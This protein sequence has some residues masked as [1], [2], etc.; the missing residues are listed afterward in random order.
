MIKLTTQ[1]CLNYSILTAIGSAFAYFVDYFKICGVEKDD[2]EFLKK[3]LSILNVFLVSLSSFGQFGV[4]LISFS[5]ILNWVPIDRDP[6]N[7]PSL[8]SIYKNGS[9]YLKIVDDNSLLPLVK[10][11][12]D[13]LVQSC[14]ISNQYLE[15]LRIFTNGVANY[16]LDLV[17]ADAS[18]NWFSRYEA[19]MVFSMFNVLKMTDHPEWL[20]FGFRII[21]HFRTDYPQ[22]LEVLDSIFSALTIFND[23]Y[24]VYRR[25]FTMSLK[26]IPFYNGENVP[27]HWMYE[28]ISIAPQQTLSF[29]TFILKEHP[30]LIGHV[31]ATLRFC[32]LCLVLLKGDNVFD[33]SIRGCLEQSFNDVVSNFENIDLNSVSLSEKPFYDLYRELVTE[34]ASSSYGD[35]L[36]GKLVVLPLAQKFDIC[37]RKLMWSEFMHA[38]R[39]VILPKNIENFVPISIFTTPVERDES[40]LVLYLNAVSRNV[41]TEKRNGFMYNVAVE[42]VRK[43]LVLEDAD[44]NLQKIL[45]LRV[46]RLKD[47]NLRKMLLAKSVS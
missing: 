47:D 35:H 1:K 24:L 10:P 23:A 25:H 45:F 8:C 6:E 41:L 11:L 16:F 28:P 32:H 27:S 14:R 12:A 5:Q 7:L 21:S 3:I 9:G 42:N 2:A 39:V 36:F 17:D 30:E 31:P 34:Y 40:L 43:Y 15:Y 26:Q 4:K 38:L 22:V 29:L 19:D 37:Y 18:S 33:E 46:N 20:N 44:Q 13:F